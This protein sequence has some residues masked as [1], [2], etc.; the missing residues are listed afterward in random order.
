MVDDQWPTEEHRV[1]SDDYLIGF[2]QITL[3]YNHLQDLMERIFRECAPLERDYAQS[4][5]HRINNRERTDLLSAFVQANEK[6][7]NARNA[8]K[9]YVLHFDICT[10]NRNILMHVISDGLSEVT[11][12]ARF[13]KRA[14]QNPARQI[15]FH[16]SIDDL[17]LVADQM[18]ETLLFSF[19]LMGFFST[20]NNDPNSQFV[21][22]PLAL[23]D[24][25]P[26]PRRLIPHQPPETQKSG[27]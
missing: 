6:D 10:E 20:R 14:S 15:E 3:L 11:K 5:F 21:L 18:A 9:H 22:G 2:G 16:V 25:P 13:T 1:A 23:P 17:R 8:L 7:E 4:L 24:I 26:K 27:I 19:R 12:V